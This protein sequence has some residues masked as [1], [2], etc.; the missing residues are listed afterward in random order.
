MEHRGGRPYLEQKGS[1]RRTPALTAPLTSFSCLSQHSPLES[2]HPAAGVSVHLFVS[3]VFPTGEIWDLVETPNNDWLP[4]SEPFEST[5]F[6]QP[7]K[8]ISFL[9][10][11]G[12]GDIV[13]RIG[14][15]PKLSGSK[16]SWKEWEASSCHFL[17]PDFVFLRTNQV[18]T[19]ARSGFMV[20]S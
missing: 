14:A 11:F 7:S 12:D 6:Q 9:V 2:F 20:W 16:A 13:C 17:S 15:P 8:L 19:G 4:S 1:G 18:E 5:V 10:L 3:Q